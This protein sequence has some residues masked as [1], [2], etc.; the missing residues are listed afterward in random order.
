M[1]VMTQSQ[2]VDLPDLF[3]YVLV[4]E[5]CAD[6]DG[7]GLVD[8]VVDTNDDGQIQVIEAEAVMGL[9]YSHNIGSVSGIEYFTNIE[10]IQLSAGYGPPDGLDLSQSTELIE[11]Y[12]NGAHLNSI[13]VT[14]SP[15]LR[16]LEMGSNPQGGLTNIDIT[17][18][19]NLEY[20]NLVWNEL[21]SIDVSQN[22]NLLNLNLEM[23]RLTNIDVTQ[24]PN[25]E[26][27]RLGWNNLTT[28]DVSQNPK[29][30]HLFVYLNHLIELDISHNIDL[31]YLACYN[32]DLTN[33]II[34]NPNLTSL[35]ASYNQFTSLDVSN[36]PNL[37]GIGCGF[38][39]I[40]HLDFSQNTNL[41]VIGCQENQ[42]VNLNINNGNNTILTDLSTYD[43]PNLACIQ[44][45]DV[46]YANSQIC[47]IANYD[48]WCKDETTSY[49]EECSLGIEDNTITNFTLYP[50]P[51]KDIL[52]IGNTGSHEIT[53]IK[54]YDAL[55]RLVLAEIDNVNQVDIA[56]LN[57]GLLFVKIETDKGELTKKIVKN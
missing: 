52:T 35:I 24:N 45:D 2:V 53:S 46:I 50:N 1:S 11:L 14:G 25:L 17:Q 21:E 55:G 34:N 20:L 31:I 28:L 7:D 12:L 23:N 27:L 22:Q 26:Y 39:Q 16:I 57:S 51:V 15:N 19:P 43:N 49:S 32:N 9:Y 29:L 36:A 4:N 13:D 3:R 56:H 38:N 18:N 30:L 37:T 44:V 54:L 5:I 42:L 33:L 8:G 10:I 48:G 6:F 40:T 47:D 41:R